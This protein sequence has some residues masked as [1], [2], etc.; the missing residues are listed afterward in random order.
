MAKIFASM[1]QAKAFAYRNWDY[2]TA[3]Q[4]ERE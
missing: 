3:H 2:D 4:G 1:T